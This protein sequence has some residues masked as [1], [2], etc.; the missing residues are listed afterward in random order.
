MSFIHS[1]LPL[2]LCSEPQSLRHTFATFLVLALPPPFQSLNAKFQRKLVPACSSTSSPPSSHLL[3][4]MRGC[5]KVVRRAGGLQTFGSR[6]ES[7]LHGLIRP[8]PGRLCIPLSRCMVMS[9]F[10]RTAGAAADKAPGPLAAIVNPAKNGSAG[11]GA[12]WAL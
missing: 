2:I 3:V 10:T 1:E 7:A 11:Q 8:P 5:N 9:A 4:C 6:A 12:T